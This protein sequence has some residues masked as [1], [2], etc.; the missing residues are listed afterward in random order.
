MDVGR[1]EAGCS[2]GGGWALLLWLFFHAC[3]WDSLI[4]AA[5]G[6]LAPSSEFAPAFSTADRRGHWLPPDLHFKS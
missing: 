6:A 1:G 2:R 3:C 4:F 5:M